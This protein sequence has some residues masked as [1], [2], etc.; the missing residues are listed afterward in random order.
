M[1]SILLILLLASQAWG[2]DIPLAWDHDGVCT[3]YRIYRSQGS[4]DYPER[5]GTVSCPTTTFTDLNVPH[6]DLAY[7]VTAYNGE[8]SNASNEVM[9]AYYYAITKYDT[10]SNG[11]ILYMGQNQDINADYGD[12]DWVISKYYYSE[13]GSMVMILVRTTS[14]TNRAAGW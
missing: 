3:E 5:V 8:E 7:I 2:L 13:S 4:V 12:T 6:G 11:R 14:W 10:D 1:K 9:L